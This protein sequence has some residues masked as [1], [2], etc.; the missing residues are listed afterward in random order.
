MLN[1]KIACPYCNHKI[2]VGL[3]QR[4]L[5]KPRRVQ[6]SSC[7]EH[8]VLSPLIFLHVLLII[9]IIVVSIFTPWAGDI[10]ILTV[11]MIPPLLLAFSV[12][13]KKEVVKNKVGLLNTRD[14]LFDSSDRHP[15]HTIWILFSAYL[16]YDTLF[17][18][19][20]D[21]K[22]F[23]LILLFL[24]S[25]MCSFSTLWKAIFKINKGASAIA[26]FSSSSLFIIAL[27]KFFDCEELFLIFLKDVFS[28]ETHIIVFILLVSIT[29][30]L[31]NYIFKKIDNPIL[32]FLESFLSCFIML[33]LYLTP[34]FLPYAEIIN[35]KNMID[36]TT[37]LDKVKQLYNKLNE[38]QKKPF[39]YIKTLKRYR[40]GKNAKAE[41]LDK[42]Y[43]KAFN[44]LIVDTKK[45][46]SKI[47]LCLSEN[48]RDKKECMEIR[49]KNKAL[50][51]KI[52][53]QL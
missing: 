34:L 16:I 35:K 10:L 43:K 22:S 17:I 3:F 29:Y 53:S 48:S 4:L 38:E 44:K 20:L 40:K 50:T 19:D 25:I 14:K 37:D 33:F 7:G 26:F 13:L 27:M 42:L 32:T 2:F 36:K 9:S 52:G 28:K 6:C 5:R 30:Y 15:F 45:K 51:R 12:G 41:K 47:S 49:K 8:S 18:R 39:S 23:T 11:M 46:I 21:N 1:R 31:W 24:A